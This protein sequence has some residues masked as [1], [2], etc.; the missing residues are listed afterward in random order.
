MLEKVVQMSLLVLLSG[1]AAPVIADDLEA[2][3]AAVGCVASHKMD[4]PLVG[5]S[6]KQVADR[7]RDDPAA[8]ALLLGKVKEGGSGTWG[9]IP[10]MAHGHLSDDQIKPLINGILAIE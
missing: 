6:Y 4:T 10:M 5:P 1:V 9:P 8:P 7:N 2:S 3:L